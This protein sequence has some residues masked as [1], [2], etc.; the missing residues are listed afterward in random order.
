MGLWFGVPLVGK[1]KPLK[2][3]ILCEKKCIIV[4]ETKGLAFCKYDIFSYSSVCVC[5]NGI[6]HLAAQV[7]S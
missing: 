1:I 2:N 6:N 7:L 5:K 3:W 4:Q